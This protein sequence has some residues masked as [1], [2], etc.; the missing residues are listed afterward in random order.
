[1][2]A[3]KGNRF[4]EAR[5]KHGRDKI[6]ETAELMWEAACDYFVWVEDN[7]LNK[8]IVYQGEVSKDTETLMRA[9]TVK[10]LCIHWQVNTQYLTDFIDNLDLEKEQDKDF[11][12][13]VNRIREIIDTQKFE[14]ASAGLLNPNIIARDL[15][16][17][18]KQSNEH[19]GANGGAIAHSHK[20][21]WSVQPVKPINET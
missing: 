7:P 10:G 21:E 13:V 2:A 1:M 16:L 6:F 20:V 5:N 11:S 9:M 15:G 14:G 8:A 12:I 4:W 19:T 17:T 18:D 3:P